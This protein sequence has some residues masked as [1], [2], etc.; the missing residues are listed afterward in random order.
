[1]MTPNIELLKVPTELN[2]ERKFLV[3][4]LSNI[5]EQAW[6][7]S[8]RVEMCRPT[9]YDSLVK[10]QPESLPFAISGTYNDVVLW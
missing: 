6:G 5:T 4:R 8:Q 10:T 7:D 9:V 3:M 2:L 1:M